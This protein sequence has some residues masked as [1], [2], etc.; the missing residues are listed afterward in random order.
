V[1]LCT[2][3]CSFVSMLNAHVHVHVHVWKSPLC[4]VM[5]WKTRSC[6]VKQSVLLLNHY[7]P[8]G[9]RGRAYSCTPSRKTQ[10]SIRQRPAVSVRSLRVAQPCPSEDASAASRTGQ[11][12][13]SA[14]T[15]SARTCLA[16]Q[17]LK[18]VLVHNPAVLARVLPIRTQELANG[19]GALPSKAPHQPPSSPT[20]EPVS[21]C[22]ENQTL[23]VDSR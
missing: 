8:A 6:Y 7:R 21:P 16:G 22:P 1:C 3:G 17:M 5:V 19:P 18:V 4:T 10:L 12:T 9:T 11:P 13:S 23:P 15:A 20:N 2:V 14:R